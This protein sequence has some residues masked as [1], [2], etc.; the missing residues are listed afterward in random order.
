[1]LVLLATSVHLDRRDP[2][3]PPLQ[4][5][6]ERSEVPVLPVPQVPQEQRVTLVQRVLARLVTP[7]PQAPSAL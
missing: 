2:L 6:Q 1:M 7:V 3:V 5:Q 4:G